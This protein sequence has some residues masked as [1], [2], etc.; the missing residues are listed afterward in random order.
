MAEWKI[1]QGKDC[2]DSS[3]SGSGIFVVPHLPAAQ[4][5][6]SFTDTFPIPEDAISDIYAMRLSIAVPAKGVVSDRRLY[7]EAGE[8][9]EKTKGKRTP[10]KRK[11][12]QNRKSKQSARKGGK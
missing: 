9:A 12:K 11:A 5:R 10:Q 6:R 2:S 4:E 1:L 8:V 3:I 7:F